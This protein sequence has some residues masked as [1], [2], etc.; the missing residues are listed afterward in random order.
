MMNQ[1]VADPQATVL[2]VWMRNLSTGV[3]VVLFGKV[4]AGK[5]SAAYNGIMKL[6]Q[7]G[8]TGIS[9]EPEPPELFNRA[10]KNAANFDFAP[11]QLTR[12]FMHQRATDLH[13]HVMAMPD[14]Y[15]LGELRAVDES[16]HQRIKVGIH[17]ANCGKT[18]LAELH[19]GTLDQARQA[20]LDLLVL[21]GLE[22]ESRDTTFI[23][24]DCARDTN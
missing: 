17:A 6:I 7:Y 15:Y 16:T 5:T 13:S 2:P 4:G 18:A 10:L 9:V 3:C 8:H 12:K 20:L 19:A 21:N 1:L 23:F 11:G 24:H 22:E 14:F